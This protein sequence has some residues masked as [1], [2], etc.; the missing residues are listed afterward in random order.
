MELPSYFR[1]FLQDIRPTPAQLNDYKDG[2]K[3]LRERLYADERLSPIIVST[4]LQ[5][6]YRRATAIR[7]H[8]GKRADVDVIIVTRLSKDEY[9]PQTAF[10]AFIPFLE[11]HYEGKYELNGRSFGIHLFYIDLDLVITAAP[12]ESEIGILQ[13]DSVITEDTPEDV[14]DWK[15][16]TLWVPRAK[17]SAPGAWRLMEAARQEPEWRTL[18]LLIPDRDAQKWEPTHPLAQIQRT[19]EKNG[20][21]N[22]HYVN[23]VKAIK[24]WRRINHPTPK[25]P[26]GYPV[27]HL[28]WYCCPNGISSVAEGVTQTLENIAQSYRL[29]ALLKTP[30]FLADHGVPEHN[31]FARVP[32]EDFATFHAQ[33]CDAA[34]V[35][36]HALDTQN[37]RESVEGWKKLFGDKFPDAPPDRG[38]DGGDDGPRQGGYTPRTS[39]SRLG[40][41]R[42][43]S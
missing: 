6:S 20:L 11:K 4:F 29:N 1:D 41:G 15:L 24:W 26:K 13:S 10:E 22:T 18:P 17:R 30:P 43:G 19:W 12:S 40:G 27:E 14:E 34:K 8:E 28:I 2:H 42:F 16:A 37:L 39:S 36:R 31:V 32:G 35:A 21:C 25:Y 5:G 9:N 33:V 3:R 23:V 7:P 38:N